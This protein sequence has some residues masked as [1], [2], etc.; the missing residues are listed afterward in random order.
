MQY[1]DQSYSCRVLPPCSARYV[2]NDDGDVRAR[3]ASSVMLSLGTSV[4]DAIADNASSVG[5]G[6]HAVGHVRDPARRPRRHLLEFQRRDTLEQ[7]R[8]GAEGEG[9]DV[10]PQL[11]DQ[12]GGEVLVDGGRAAVDGTSPPPAAVRACPGRTRFRR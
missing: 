1:P 7:P 4:S 11:V 9:H 8:A 10:Q 12:A 2:W 5:S 3:R 6:E